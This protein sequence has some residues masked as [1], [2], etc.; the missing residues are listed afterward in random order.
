M[1]RRLFKIL[2]S[3]AVVVLTVLAVSE[4]MVR[5]VGY[6]SIYLYDPIYMPYESGKEI[7]F[8]MKPDLEN[9]RA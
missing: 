6:S 1:M 7:P 5:L 8:V 9:V 3:A 2:A 4:A